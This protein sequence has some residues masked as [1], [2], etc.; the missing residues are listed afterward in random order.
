MFSREGLIEDSNE[1]RRDGI[2]PILCAIYNKNITQHVERILNRIE[3]NF[4]RTFAGLKSMSQGFR[5]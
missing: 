5:I 1:V 4:N 2:F 3:D